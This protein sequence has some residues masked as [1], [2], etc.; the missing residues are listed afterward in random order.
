M[1]PAAP[2]VER[3]TVWVDT[4]QRG[5][6]LRAV[7]GPGTLVPE[8]MR[9]VSAVTAGR[10]ELIHVR[11]GATVTPESPLMELSNPDVQL[12]AL[13]A[14]R[15]LTDAESN[16][17]TLRTSLESQRL[18]QRAGLEQLRTQYQDA[19][20][21]ADL[22]Q[23][24]GEKKLAS[25]MEI[26]KAVEAAADLKSRVELEGQRLAVLESSIERQ[27]AF[28]EKNVQ[29]L[30]DIAQ[31]QE[32]RVASM[33]V[34]A[35]AA[36]VIQQLDWEPGQ[37]ANPGAVLARIAEPGRLKAELR[38]PETQAKDV[39][40]GQVA[41]IDTRNGIVAGRVARVEPAVVNGTVLVEVRLEGE[42]PRGARPDLSVDGTIEIERLADVLHV[43]RPAVGQA[44]STISLFRLE[45]DGRTALR[46]PVQ[47]GRSSV[48]EIEILN[49]LREGDVV[50]LSDL[51]QYDSNDRI[52]LK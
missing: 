47:L 27:V 40:I 10:V 34:K 46:V 52:R 25:D 28:Q 15:Q 22:M 5:S 31:F 36:G 19:R 21:T 3:Q 20:R 41:Q 50:V 49:G 30:R 2:E 4:V 38:I 6:M 43:G 37:W 35:G 7:R 12:Q 26:T 33:Q 23:T 24:L 8:Q 45:P 13:E 14:Q 9:W 48:N 1:E 51:T 44:Q 11:P 29:R 32:N 16:L 39:Q 18:S 17:V 42:L